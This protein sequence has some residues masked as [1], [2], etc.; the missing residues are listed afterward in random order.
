M[1]SSQSHGIGK[2]GTIP[3]ATS[4]LIMRLHFHN[5]DVIDYKALPEP[6]LDKNYSS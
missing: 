4:S 5:Q 1:D 6:E 3:L 2:A